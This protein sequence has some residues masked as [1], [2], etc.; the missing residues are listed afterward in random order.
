MTKENKIEQNKSEA[1]ESK[2][3]EPMGERVQEDEDWNHLENQESRGN[4]S[5]EQVHQAFLTNSEMIVKEVL[6]E[7]GLL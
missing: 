5:H 6:L 2:V 3:E 7:S 1:T 4:A